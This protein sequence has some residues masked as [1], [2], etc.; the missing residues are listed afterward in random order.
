MPMCSSS[1]GRHKYTIRYTMTRM[2]RQFDDHDELYWNATGN[3]WN[4]PISESVASITLPDGAVIDDLVGYTGRT[5]ST[6]Q[7][8]T[9]TR[10]SDNQAI[11][12]T[13]RRLAPG[14]GLSVAASFQKGILAAPTANRELLWWLSDHRE[15]VVP[16]IAVFLVLLYNLLA[17]SSVG[18]D[19]KKGTI[20]PLFHPPKGFSPALIHYIHRMGWEKSGW[21]AFTAAI[22]D[23]GVKGLVESSTTRASR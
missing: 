12:R 15:L 10:V 3:Y 18:R 2:A 8:V 20:I 16:A 13:T 6:E 1:Y 14:E 5:G 21:T 4:F 19:P 11:F 23:L 9:I 7:A 22:F 17:W